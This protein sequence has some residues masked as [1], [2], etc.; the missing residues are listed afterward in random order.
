[1]KSYKELL[2]NLDLHIPVD[3]GH[4]VGLKVMY[5][6]LTRV[7]QLLLFINEM[8]LSVPEIN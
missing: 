5:V 4:D 3:K 8:M 2:P 7:K 6:L 1:M